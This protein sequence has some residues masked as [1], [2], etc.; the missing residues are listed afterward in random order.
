MNSKAKIGVVIL[1][2]GASKRLGKPKQLLKYEKKPLLQHVIDVSN[3]L[4]CYPKVLVLGAYAKQIESEIDKHNFKI[5]LNPSWEK[6]M[7][8][9]I[10]SGI[11]KCLE[12]EPSLNGILF[13]LT[14]QPYVTEE[15]L[16]KLLKKY[17]VGNSSI[18]GS[19]YKETVGV[20]SIFDRRHFPELL[21]L[22]E[23]QG[24]RKLIRKYPEEVASIEFE[25]GSLDIDTQDDYEK[26][27]KIPS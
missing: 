4:P 25:M 1:A 27:L 16:E 8:T 26:L 24:A 14:D 21:D 2:G 9:S 10:A 5:Q 7:S 19:R 23:D 15:I 20:P 18:T 13:L 17:Q 12:L 11:K 3:N 6:G 22:T